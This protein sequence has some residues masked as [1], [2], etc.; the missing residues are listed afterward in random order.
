MA[1]FEAF[2]SLSASD[3]IAEICASPVGAM[4][5]LCGD[6]ETSAASLGSEQGGGGSAA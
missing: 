3:R 1:I 4:V 2:G 5:G 6:D